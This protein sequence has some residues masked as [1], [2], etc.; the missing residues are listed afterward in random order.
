MKE[1]KDEEEKRKEENNGE[2]SSYGT[3][4]IRR[5]LVAEDDSVPEVIKVRLITRTIFDT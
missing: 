1:E 5:R 4:R 2:I 3:E